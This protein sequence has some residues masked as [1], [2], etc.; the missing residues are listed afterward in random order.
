MSGW[1]WYPFVERIGA[2]DGH[3]MH[4]PTKGQLKKLAELE[5]EHP[6]YPK[7]LFYCAVYRF[8]HSRDDDEN[9]Y[10]WKGVDSMWDL[11]LSQAPIWLEIGK[12][13]YQTRIARST[14]KK[15]VNFNDSF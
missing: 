4:A 9:D 14:L 12:E 10:P 8:V 2:G 11:F 5:A 15:P 1:W 3:K 6:E 13:E 7:E